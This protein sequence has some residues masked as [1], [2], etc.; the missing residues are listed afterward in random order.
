MLLQEVIDRVVVLQAYAKGWLGARRY[1]R[2]RERREKAAI[3]I[4]S[5]KRS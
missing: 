5:G 3:A 4:Q 2:I 1:K